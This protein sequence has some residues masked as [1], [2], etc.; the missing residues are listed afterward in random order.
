MITTILTRKLYIQSA[1]NSILECVLHHRDVDLL[2][3]FPSARARVSSTVLLNIVV[4]LVGG[5]GGGGGGGVVVA[6]VVFVLINSF[7]D[8]R[9]LSRQHTVKLYLADQCV[10]AQVV[11]S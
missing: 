3:S 9:R 4:V 11:A 8:D 6:V 5:G 10:R 2:F 7:V 1:N